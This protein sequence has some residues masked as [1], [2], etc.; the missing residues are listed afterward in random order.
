MPSD[1]PPA[2]P[3]NPLTEAS[4]QSLDELFSRDP[5]ELSNQ[6]IAVIVAK[7]R[8]LREQW[9]VDEAQGKTK[10]RRAE[11]VPQGGEPKRKLSLADLGLKKTIG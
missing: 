11:A 8:A 6:D 7:F 1:S 10:G 4:P 5:L 9:L 2:S 3:V